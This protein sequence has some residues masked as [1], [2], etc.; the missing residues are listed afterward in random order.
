MGDRHWQG[1]DSELNGG[2]VGNQFGNASGYFPFYTG[3]Q[4]IRHVDKAVI[5]VDQQVDVVRMYK[6]VAPRGGQRRVDQRDH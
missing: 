5:A 1:P 2:A 3:G 6:C 4:W